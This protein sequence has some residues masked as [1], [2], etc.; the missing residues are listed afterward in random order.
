MIKKHMSK[1]LGDATS[2]RNRFSGKNFIFFIYNKVKFIFIL[3]PLNSEK[4]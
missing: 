2:Y 3:S 4:K 1:I